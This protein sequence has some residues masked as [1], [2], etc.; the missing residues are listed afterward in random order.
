[1]TPDYKQIYADEVLKN[2]ILRDKIKEIRK[3]LNEEV[4]K[5]SMALTLITKEKK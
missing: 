4:K 1:M 2:R 5:I 3:Y